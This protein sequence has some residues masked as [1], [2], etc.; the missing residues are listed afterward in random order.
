MPCDLPINVKL[1][2]QDLS[3]LVFR[4]QLNAKSPDFNGP[5]KE[6]KKKKKEV[7]Y[8]INFPCFKDFCPFL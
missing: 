2:C 6:T 5:V 4:A 3:S 1:K 8:A 7:L